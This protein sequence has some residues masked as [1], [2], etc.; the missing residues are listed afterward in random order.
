M[1]YNDCKKIIDRSK[2]SYSESPIDERYRLRLLEFYLDSAVEVPYRGHRK[3]KFICPF[4]GSMS[5]KEYKKKEKKGSLLW[6]ARQNSWI[7]SCAKHGSTECMNSKN[8]SNFIS[9]LNPALG[10][11]YRRDRWHSGTTGK[12]HN[13]RAPQSVIGITTGSY[14]SMMSNSRP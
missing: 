11:A 2:M 13:C 9:A 12:G 10:E 4:C 1:P 7:F 3:W 6:D 14:G 5:S 8:F